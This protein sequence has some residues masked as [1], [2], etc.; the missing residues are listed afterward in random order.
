MVSFTEMDKDGDMK[1]GVRVQMDKLYLIVIEKS[2]KEIASRE[3]IPAL[4]E[5]G[6]YHN[7]IHPMHGNV[8]SGSRPP[9]QHV[10]EKI[11]CDKFANFFLIYDER[12]EMVGT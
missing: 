5:S 12:L 4:K 6:K 2:M 3:S 7:F 11:V 10:G 9:L 1:N 8:F